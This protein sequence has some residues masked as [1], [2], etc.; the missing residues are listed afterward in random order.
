MLKS[1]LITSSFPTL[2]FP[3]VININYTITLLF[4]LSDDNA[5]TYRHV[6]CTMLNVSRKHLQL[7]LYYRFHKYSIAGRGLLCTLYNTVMHMHTHF[8]LEADWS[9]LGIV[10]IVISEKFVSYVK[11]LLFICVIIHFL[12]SH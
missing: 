11:S 8:G 4:S 1:L 12:T 3:N 10:E 9:R 5:C 6:C 2:P 7:K